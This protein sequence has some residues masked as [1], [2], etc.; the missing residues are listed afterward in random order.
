[1][2]RQRRGVIFKTSAL[3]NAE[4][5]QLLDHRQRD[6]RQVVFVRAERIKLGLG[7]STTVLR[8]PARDP[9]RRV[10]AI[11]GVTFVEVSWEEL[12]EDGP[13][14]GQQVRRRRDEGS[15]DLD[16]SAAA[17]EV[18]DGSGEVALD[19]VVDRLCDTRETRVESGDELSCGQRVSSA[20]PSG[21]MQGRATLKLTDEPRFVAPVCWIA[22]ESWMRPLVSMR[23]PAALSRSVR[24]PCR[25]V[26]SRLM[27][28][29]SVRNE[30]PTV[31]LVSHATVS[32]A[33]QY[34]NCTAARKSAYESVAFSFGVFI[35]R[36]VV[37]VMAFPRSTTSPLMSDNPLIPSMRFP[38]L[39]LVTVLF[40][41]ASWVPMVEMEDWRAWRLPACL[42][43]RSLAQD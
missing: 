39:N 26:N 13:N 22:K 37:D 12:R 20:R 32:Q 38:P 3:Y 15:G 33:T 18:G 34:M 17:L 6:S 43:S 11:L 4:F 7:D 16:H 40:V 5:L 30:A 10:A 25:L 19:L 42:C 21:A 36:S 8:L 9:L 35:A 14:L 1:M 41:L 31:V 2:R 29:C 27:F 24:L 23:P 28:G